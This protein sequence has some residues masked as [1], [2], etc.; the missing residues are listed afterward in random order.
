MKALSSRRVGR[1]VASVA[2]LALAGSLLG[3]TPRAS[4]AP[5]WA[6]PDGVKTVEVGGYPISYI[7]AGSGVPVVILHGAWVDHRLFA[8]QV[9]DFSKN[10]RAIAVS[11][12]HY[13]PEPWDGKEGSFSVTQHANDVAALIRQ[14]N[15]GKVHLLGHSRG[16]AVAITVARQSPELVRTLILEDPGG[17]EPLLA[18]AAVGRQRVEGSARLGAFLRGTLDSSDRATTAKTAWNTTNGPDAWTRMP[19]AM[20]QMITDNIGTMT[21]KTPYDAP[22]IHCD[23]IRKFSFPVLVLHGDRSQKIYSDMGAAMRQCKPDLA[24]PVIVP[25]AGHNMHVNNPAFF[26]KAVIDFMQRN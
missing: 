19:P 18:D 4:A 3:G 20:Q 10:N 26:N 17:L 14:L 12:R 22:A 2:V 8:P 15:L 23:D 21:A 1:T 13:H 25:E 16:G 9:T 24:E 6:I 5:A 7:E 11:L